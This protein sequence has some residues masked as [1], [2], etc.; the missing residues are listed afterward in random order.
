M[1][2]TDWMIELDSKTKFPQPV[3]HDSK[4]NVS[5]YDELDWVMRIR[6]ELDEVLAAKTKMEKAQ[7]IVD[8]ITVGISW[9]NQLGFDEAARTELYE[10]SNC[11]NIGR[12]YMRAWGGEGHETQKNHPSSPANPAHH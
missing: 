1:E 9:L 12:G 8:A 6:E 4:R 11:K 3:L 10:F 5:E 2:R 7:E